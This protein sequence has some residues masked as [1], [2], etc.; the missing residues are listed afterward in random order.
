MSE[1][2]K[3]ADQATNMRT[4]VGLAITDPEFKNQIVGRSPDQIKQAIDSHQQ[5]LGITSTSL[6][7]DSLSAL[8]SI[9]S[10]EIDTLKQIYEKVRYAGIRPL[11]ML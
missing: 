5:A 2:Y 6:S 11:D 3:S 4:V 10:S 8:S 9:T 1:S 7:D